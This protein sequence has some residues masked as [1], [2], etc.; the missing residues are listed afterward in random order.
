MKLTRQQLYD[1]VWSEP[2]TTISK[3]FGLSDNGLRKHCKSMNIPTP[4]IGYWAKLQYNHKVEKTPLP[5]ELQIKKTEVNLKEIE[6]TLKDKSVNSV[7]PMD[8]VNQREE[9]IKIGD[10]SAFEVPDVLY[11]KDSIII[12]TKEYYRPKDEHSSKYRQNNPYTSKIKQ[13]LNLFVDYKSIDRALN[14]FSTI[15]KALRSRG[16]D[17][18]IKENTTYAVIKGE[19]ID[20]IIKEKQ[21]RIPGKYGPDFEFSS[22]LSFNI[23]YNSY[24]SKVFN[25]GLSS[26]LED[27]II[28]IVA[29]LEIIAEEIIARNIESEK[30]RLKWE[31]EKRLQEEFEK[32]QNIELKRFKK[33][34]YMTNRYHATKAMT[35]YINAIET[36]A[37]KNS[38]ISDELKEQIKW[39]REKIDWFDPFIAKKDIYLDKF[40]KDE[41]LQNKDASY[42][43]YNEYS[44]SEK[45]QFPFWLIYN[46]RR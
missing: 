12:D 9:E 32:Q 22:Q 11:A 6:D 15:I 16:H 4:P 34:L 23:K 13:H 39:A 31:A 25:D 36:D 38:K 28:K 41:L 14:I 3:R 33:L 40:D 45:S 30:K 35:E 43:G 29:S 8:K 5:E 2:M 46:N 37:Q 42:N 21:H 27:K 1:L 10:I 19:K 7:R 17:I 44:R 18:E 20:I 24:S 26:K